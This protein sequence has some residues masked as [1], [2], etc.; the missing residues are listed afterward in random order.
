MFIK[1]NNEN[2]QNYF[3]KLISENLYS[4]GENCFNAKSKDVIKRDMDKGKIGAVL[5][6]VLDS[7]QDR[8]CY[9]I[10]FSIVID[11]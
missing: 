11:K 1:R 6:S 8:S 7:T 5:Y 3:N 10:H 2:S 4:L 9:L